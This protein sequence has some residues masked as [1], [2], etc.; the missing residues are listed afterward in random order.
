MRSNPVLGRL[1]RRITLAFIVF[2]T[3]LSLGLGLSLVAGL[4]SVEQSILDDTL[5]LELAHF[6]G[7]V[8][9]AQALGAF[10]SRTTVIHT[11]PLDEIHTLPEL[12]RDL[13]VGTHDVTDTGRKYRVLV[14]ELDGIRYIVMFDD[15]N[16]QERERQFGEWVWWSA[17]GVLGLSG[18]FGW[19]IA[20][21]LGKPTQ[22]LAAQLGRLTNQPS[23]NLDLTDF[24][25]DE[26]GQLAQR[27]K[28]YHARL[29][30]LLAREKE[31]AGNV[32]HELRTPVTTISL[33]SEI[34]AANPNLT[35]KQT[36]PV[37][38]I[39]R[40]TREMSELVDTFLVLSKI[41]DEVETPYSACDLRPIVE[42]AVAQQRVW[43]GNKPVDVHIE[44]RTPVSVAAPPKVVS[45]LIANLIR[46]AFR[47][48]NVGAIT[49]TMTDDT[50]SVEDTG[51][52][53]DEATQARMFDRHIS[54]KVGSRDG[55]GLGLSIVS[56][57]C[58]RY[59]WRVSCSSKAG[60]G[61]IFTIDFTPGSA[62]NSVSIHK[63]M[64]I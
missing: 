28:S 60:E 57:I 19:W 24:S 11:A 26:I 15:T 2:G 22:H 54:G 13:P 48:T 21:R 31:F 16:I 61:S 37:R 47:Y 64:R 36:D 43:L 63:P 53:I 58:D 42:D 59:G 23:E 10:H 44:E 56:R 30:D 3:A 8:E 35:D 12:V 32:S 9:L 51:V 7:T 1:G 34:L 14:E 45:V 4:K 17:A 50:V 49:V 40:A 29:S 33:A 55:A 18:L 27:L 39:Q 5:H 52:G 41:D 46:N 25:D 6:R 38:R 62:S 20:R